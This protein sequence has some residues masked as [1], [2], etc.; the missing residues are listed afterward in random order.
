MINLHPPSFC[1]VSSYYFVTDASVIASWF[2]KVL[3]I[4]VHLGLK[5]ILSP[6]LEINSVLQLENRLSCF[7]YRVLLYSLTAKLLII[8]GNE[9]QNCNEV[10]SVLGTLSRCTLPF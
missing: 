9:A 2:T 8:P 4:E 1:K 7:V 6:L 3:R 10:S 5:N